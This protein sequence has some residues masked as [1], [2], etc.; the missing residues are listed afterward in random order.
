MSWVG[1]RELTEK[2]SGMKTGCLSA[3]SGCYPRLDVEMSEPPGLVP[4][5]QL[6][7]E[8]REKVE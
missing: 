1:I 7:A 3:T 4:C 6:S 5:K 2:D 8:L